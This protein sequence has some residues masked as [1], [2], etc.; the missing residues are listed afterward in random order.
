MAA[1]NY[2]ALHQSESLQ[3]ILD[4]RPCKARKIKCIRL[5]WGGRIKRDQAGTGSDAPSCNQYQTTFSFEENL[6]PLLS[7]SPRPLN[8]HQDAC[9]RPNIPKSAVSQF[10]VDQT[11]KQTGQANV[12]PTLDSVRNLSQ[13]SCFP[14]TSTASTASPY[15]PHRF[16]NPFDFPSALKRGFE[17]Y[18]CHDTGF[19]PSN[20]DMPPPRGFTEPMAKRRKHSSSAESPATTA[21]DVCS[22]NTGPPTPY[23]PYLSMPLTPISPVSSD[24]ATSRA[25]QRNQST[26][27]TPA[28]LH[29]VSV[30]SLIHRGPEGT[31]PDHSSGA[32]H[33]HQ[34]SIADKSFTTYGYDCGLPDYDTPNNADFAAIAIFSAQDDVRD[35]QDEDTYGSADSQ[36]ERVA[37]GKGGYYAKPVPIRISKALGTLPPLL[38][39]NPMNLLY[40]H[41]FLNHTARILVP[42]D[43]ER[44]PFRQILPEMAVHDE[45]IMNLLLAYSAAHRARMLNHRE[46][47]NRIAVWVQDVFPRLRQTLIDNPSSISDNTLAVVIMLA[48]LE[49]ICSGTFEV[50]ISWQNHLTMARQLII[51]RG[52]PNALGR[53]NRVAYF[54]SRWFAYLDVVGS[55]SGDKND[56][57]L[58]SSYW[59]SSTHASASASGS[60]DVDAQPDQ[61][62]DFEIDCLLGF[63]THCVANLA[64]ISELAKLCKPQRIDAQGNVRPNWTPDPAIIQEAN[65]IGAALQ[66]GLLDCNFSDACTHRRDTSSPSPLSPNQHSEQQQHPHH[67]PTTPAPEIHATNQLFHWAGL[68]HLYRRVLA[69]P[70]PDPLVQHAVRQIVRLL[71]DIRR[72]S[73]AEACL[74]FPM[75]AAGCEALEPGTRE[76]IMR[77]LSGVEGFGL[78][79]VPKISNLMR[80]VWDTGKPWESLVSGEFFG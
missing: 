48:S 49:I 63:T 65:K 15:V 78:T 10:I 26:E 18:Q 32:V 50:P 28:D 60:A 47:T 16:Q 61:D 76:T 70:A 62:Q 42:H 30:Q 13:Q 8:R 36:L 66:Q 9:P 2:T 21:S 64:R 59:T 80:R 52:G 34:H 31:I 51:A 71:G 23:S 38:M 72:G 58:G 53:H 17:P 54:L 27:Y 75:F 1:G 41:H 19:I 4:H 68:L 25:S 67:T 79:H 55:L 20:V 39:E 56:M 3:L 12:D 22:P 37:F 46:P 74:I 44:N 24:E 43:C 45:N 6:S 11:M 14:G 57:M 7:T 29:R 77:R 33:R 73:S 69:K 5:N 35:L 40:F